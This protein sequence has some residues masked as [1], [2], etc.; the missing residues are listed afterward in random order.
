MTTWAELCIEGDPC[1]ATWAAICM[2]AR[3]HIMPSHSDRPYGRAHVA[4]SRWS[5]ATQATIGIDIIT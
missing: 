4:H 3:Y 5:V 1:M 2:T